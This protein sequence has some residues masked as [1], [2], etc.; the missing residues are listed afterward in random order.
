M[1][2]C[3]F[4]YGCRVNR[5]ES[6][7]IVK[8]LIERGHDVVSQLC[9][10]D[11][12]VVNTCAVT[13]EAERKSRQSINRI[14]HYNKDAKILVCGCASQKDKESYL[15]D[16]VIY[17][18]GTKDKLKLADMIENGGV[19]DFSL[20]CS[21]EECRALSDRSKFYLKVQDGCNNFCSYCIIPYLRGRSR[22]RDITSCV[23]E[24]IESQAPE[25]VLTGINLSAYGLDNG[26]TLVDLINALSDIDARIS[27]GSLE[28]GIVDDEFLK[29][30]KGLKHFCPHFHLSLQSGSNK[31]LK[32]MN[33][34]YTREEYKSACDLIKTYFD[35]PCITT[36]VIVGFP[37]ETEVDFLDT[38][39][40]CSS[41]AFS[42]IHVFPYSKRE[43]TNAYKLGS[44]NCKVVKD[45]VV[46]LESLRDQLRLSYH[47]S[48][49]G[50]TG[51]VLIEEIVDGIAV[52]YI[53]RYVKT[54]VDRDLKIGEVVKVNI[55]KPY[56]DGVLAK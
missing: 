12:Y 35:N 23:N 43:G 19:G 42:D 18:S 13:A 29:A 3:V 2:I 16:G 9:R 38:M 48:L 22:S 20:D 31:V 53:E 45:R 10:A 1:K 39:E 21:Y 36:D 6:D 41:V 46:R 50:K 7:A 11:V 14:K 37:T 40:L 30:L 44:I 26:H 47:D 8:I 54:Y 33:R 56:L 5:Y 4:T 15:R 52:G 51:E 55:E 34:H 28:V 49:I 27:L 32:D 24:A 17:V 25:I